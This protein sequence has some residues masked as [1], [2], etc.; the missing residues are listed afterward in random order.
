MGRPSHEPTAETRL[1]VSALATA[2]IK[3]DDIATAIEVSDDTLR[4]YYATELKVA[5]LQMHALAVNTA[6]R[7]M[8]SDEMG[9]AGNVAKFYLERRLGW[10]EKVTVNDDR[11]RE[12]RRVVVEFVGDSAPSPVTIEHE[13]PQDRTGYEA[14]RRNVQ[15]VG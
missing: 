3:H 9:P 4:K 12:P 2:G 11:E 14:A 5:Q 1:V 8:M 10:T 15:L 7:V 6:R 13:K